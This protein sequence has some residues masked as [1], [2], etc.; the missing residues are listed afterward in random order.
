[1]RQGD[2]PDWRS[3]GEYRFIAG[4]QTMAEPQFLL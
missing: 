1:M 2:R 3:E 4:E